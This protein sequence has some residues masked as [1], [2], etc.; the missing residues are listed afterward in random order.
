[1]HSCRQHKKSEQHDGD[2][3]DLSRKSWSRRIGRSKVMLLIEKYTQPDQEYAQKYQTNYLIANSQKCRIVP[4]PICPA[5][6]IKS[7]DRKS[8][9]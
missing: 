9:V 6:K 3:D 2:R 8:V 5:P 4:D 7:I 1:M